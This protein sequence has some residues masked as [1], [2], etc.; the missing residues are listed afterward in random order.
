MNINEIIAATL[1]TKGIP[2]GSTVTVELTDPAKMPN[3]AKLQAASIY[4]VGPR[5]SAFLGHVRHDGA[6]GRFVRI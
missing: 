5:R 2:K 3:V 1:S 6:I 4:V